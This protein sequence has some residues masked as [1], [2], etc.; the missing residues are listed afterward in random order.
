MERKLT[1][2][3]GNEFIKQLEFLKNKFNSEI[4]TGIELFEI[5]KDS[6]ENKKLFK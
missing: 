1:D 5:V 2:I 3:S 6:T 4:L